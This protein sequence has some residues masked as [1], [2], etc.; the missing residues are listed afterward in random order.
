MV[1]FR[2]LRQ[3][4][5][6]IRVQLIDA[7]YQQSFVFNGIQ[8]SCDIGSEIRRL[9]PHQQFAAHA[10]AEMRLRPKVVFA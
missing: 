10:G 3:E 5:L 2:H 7:E 9:Q 1:S 8:R 6:Q 4:V